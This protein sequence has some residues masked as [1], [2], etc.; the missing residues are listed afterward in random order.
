MRSRQILSVLLVAGCLFAFTSLAGSLD[1]SISG[2]PDDLV[3][4][5]SGLL[6]IDSDQLG[7]VSDSLN[8][9]ETTEPSAASPRDVQQSEGGSAAANP[10]GDDGGAGA[11]DGTRQED[12][13]GGQTLLEQLLQLLEELLPAFLG[14]LLLGA[15]AA[16]IHYRDRIWDVI[17]RYLGLDAPGGRETTA[18]NSP[19]SRPPENEIERA[20]LEM[21]GSAD[22][23]VEPSATPREY[24]SAAVSD[25][26]HQDPV[27]E[28]TDL[29]ERAR[30]GGGQ[31]TTEGV[32][33]AERCLR[34]SGD[35]PER[36]PDV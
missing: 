6:P 5:D 8:E 20:W 7:D 30:Y 1:S 36:D 15:L 34:E 33:H 32:T 18:S 27:W 16:L 13:A 3:D 11:V 23:G 22:V 17:A 24:A 12:G 26:L 28:L 35:R 9:V 4:I 25:G 2:G 31:I 19:L 10:S 14:L 29:F 21:V